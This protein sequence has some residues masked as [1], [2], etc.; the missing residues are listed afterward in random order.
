MRRDN[1]E[2]VGARVY[3]APAGALHEVTAAAAAAAASA[4]G[5]H[6]FT[7]RLRWVEEEAR[8]RARRERED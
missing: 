3:T 6:S 4:G 8:E 1:E 7:G 5:R 2:P